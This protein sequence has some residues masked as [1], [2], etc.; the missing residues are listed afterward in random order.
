MKFATGLVS[1]LVP[2]LVVGSFFGGQQTVLDD[3]LDIP[4]DNSLHFC[5]KD[6][7]YTL[8]I[9]KVDLDPNPPKA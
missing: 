4:G 2:T 5:S 3:D 6:D 7:S 9:T 1:V 8:E